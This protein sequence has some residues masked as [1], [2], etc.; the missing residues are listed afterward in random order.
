ML[1]DTEK[2]SQNESMCSEINCGYMLDAM[3]CRYHISY[4][5]GNLSHAMPWARSL[6][7]VAFAVFYAVD[8]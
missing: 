3:L 8:L 6:S 4:K 2:H 7:H 1:H 5:Y